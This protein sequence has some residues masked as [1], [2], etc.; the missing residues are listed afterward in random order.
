[1]ANAY[2]YLNNFNEPLYTPNFGLISQALQFKQQNLNQNRANLQK[3][4]DDTISSLDL[5]KDVDKDYA[6]ERIAQVTD[7]VNQYAGQN[8]ANPALAQALNADVSQIIDDKVRNAV[9]STAIYRAEQKNWQDFKE[10]NPEEFSQVNYAYAQR[11]VQDYLANT[12]PGAKYNGGGG[13]VPYVDVDKKINEFMPKYLKDK[14][15]TQKIVNGQAKYYD[16]IKEQEITKDQVLLGLN[17]VLGA[18]D[19]NQLAINAWGSFRGADDAT[20]IG[21]YAKNINNNISKYDDIIAQYDRDL[22]NK[23]LT[24]DEIN[25]INQNKERYKYEKNKLRD[26]D[27]FSVSRDQAA[28]EM[29]SK[30]FNEKFTSAYSIDNKQIEIKRD[31]NQ[32]ELEKMKQAFEIDKLT[33][34]TAADLEKAN[35]TASAKGTTKNANGEP[36][37][38]N[39]VTYS[40]TDQDGVEPEDTY[41]TLSNS[42]Q[43]NTNSL[44]EDDII[45]DI[46]AEGV[47]SES[48]LNKI[49]NYDGSLKFDGKD[50]TPAQRATLLQLDDD[51]NK[52]VGFNTETLE[53]MDKHMNKVWKAMVTADDY[54][55]LTD[56]DDYKFKVVTNAN[57]D[58]ELVPKVEGD[59]TYGEIVTAYKSPS[60][61]K[62]LSEDQIETAK[63]YTELNYA[64]SAF[65]S[66]KSDINKKAINTFL[67]DK[68]GKYKNGKTFFPNTTSDLSPY[69]LTRIN[70]RDTKYSE[71]PNAIKANYSIEYVNALDRISEELLDGRTLL[72]PANRN[73]T[74]GIPTEIDVIAAKI[75]D[76]PQIPLTESEAIAKAKLENKDKPETPL[77]TRD[78][79]KAVNNLV[80]KSFS[81]SE[82]EKLDGRFSTIGADDF[83]R[84]GE[85][86]FDVAT[87]DGYDFGGSY[88]NEVAN[89]LKNTRKL[90]NFNKQVQQF[91]TI[92]E[93]PIQ[94][95]AIMDKL[96]ANGLPYTLKKDGKISIEVDAD[97]NAI[98]FGEFTKKEEGKNIDVSQEEQATSIK[99]AAEE[100]VKLGLGYNVD[101]VTTYD[102]TLGEKANKKVKK[103]IITPEA[104]A[105]VAEYFT[106]EL[107]GSTLVGNNPQTLID[108][109]QGN[110]EAVTTSLKVNEEGN[111]YVMTFSA[112]DGTE[113]YR[114]NVGG[115]KLQL[116]QVTGLLQT[117]DDILLYPEPAQA[118][119]K[120]LRT[121]AVKSGVVTMANQDINSPEYQKNYLKDQLTKKKQ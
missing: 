86:F 29:Y 1:M 113:F 107:E 104:S 56:L 78:D 26:I 67:L 70:V 18:N 100:V 118:Y 97:N 44:I 33:I 64:I 49:N 77:L 61:R 116:G 80:R 69:S 74:G 48:V 111:D 108:F 31:I 57:G 76:N 14:G 98:V 4:Y 59:L 115:S 8:L 32:F 68:S 11:G 79:I 22:E 10:K 60:A 63:A 93:D 121:Q 87:L 75:K 89:V 66:D 109:V 102:V 58:K 92:V 17:A 84:Y 88:K 95:R 71:T 46:Y 81:N 28:N 85:G 30:A 47:D 42:I 65:D 35:R 62:E 39:R 23:S 12:E 7:L 120:Y 27:P 117:A 20:V 5:L 43:K 103:T 13:V 55:P 82:T 99:L 41:V 96:L 50:I 36:I 25:T 19:K 16:T 112:G 83:E 45:E 52:V 2:S 106:R 94:K 21:E 114:Y 119:A 6:N 101:K 73:S 110:Q 40:V 34:K 9:G 15:I 90:D 51:Y 37:L 24:L 105:N 53:T 91:T 54:N 3:Y 72:T 38:E